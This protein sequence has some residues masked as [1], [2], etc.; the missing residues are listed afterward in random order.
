VVTSLTVLAEV[1]E[2]VRQTMALMWKMH[3]IDHTSSS[4]KTRVA[5]TRRCCIIHDKQAFESFVLQWWETINY[6]K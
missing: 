3:L 1:A 4:V 6:F 2:K 5:G